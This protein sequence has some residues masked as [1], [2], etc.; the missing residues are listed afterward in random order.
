MGGIAPSKADARKLILVVDDDAHIRSIVARALSPTYDIREAPDGL[1]AAGEL[2]RAPQP[3]LV[4]LDVM[5]PHADG[6]TLAATMKASSE[7]RAIPII[8]LTARSSP[9]DLVQGIRI[10][11]RAYITKPFKLDDLRKKVAKILG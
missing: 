11:A 6:A 1:A 10:G 9:A 3:D 8:F 4:I 2:T 7:F 5:M